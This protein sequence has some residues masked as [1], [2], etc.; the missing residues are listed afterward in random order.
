MDHSNTYVDSVS[1]TH[2]KTNLEFRKAEKQDALLLI[3][4]YNAAFYSDYIRYGECPG[5][6]RTKEEIEESIKKTSKYI[7]QYNGIPVGVVSAASKGNGEYYI[8]CLCIIPSYQGMGFGTQAIQY[9]L[10]TYQDWRKIT[11]ITPID[12]EENI[13][14]YTKKNG[15]RIDGTLQEGN[16]KLAHFIMERKM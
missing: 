9:I 11:L 16:V 2:H 8:G 15:F 10:N 3:S 1:V 14:F 7:I 13:R 6:G 5:Y 4:L 12:K